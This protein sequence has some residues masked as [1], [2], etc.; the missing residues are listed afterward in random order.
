MATVFLTWGTEPSSWVTF[1]LIG[2]VVAVL[3]GMLLLFAAWQYAGS[4]PGD[5][6]LS[7]LG[8]ALLV[9]GAGAILGGVGLRVWGRDRTKPL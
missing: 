1:V 7:I 6:L 8:T 9:A 5:G 3:G 2:A 4:A